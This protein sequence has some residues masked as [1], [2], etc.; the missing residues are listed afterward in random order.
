M[1]VRELKPLAVPAAIGAVVTAAVGLLG[2]G[3][4]AGAMLGGFVTTF[5]GSLEYLHARGSELRGRR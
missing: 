3:W 4:R 1:N 5:W 2:G